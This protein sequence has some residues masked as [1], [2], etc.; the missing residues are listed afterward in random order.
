LLLVAFLLVNAPNY[1]LS[2]VLASVFQGHA[3][4]CNNWIGVMIFKNFSDQDWIGFSFI[5][6]GLDLDWKILQ[7]AHLWYIGRVAHVAFDNHGR[8]QTGARV[9]TLYH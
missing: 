2:L 7:S 4:N 1:H 3:V 9:T 6:S 8:L 5:G